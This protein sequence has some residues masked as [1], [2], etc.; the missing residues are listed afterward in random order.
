MSERDPKLTL[1]QMRDFASRAHAL[2]HG[3]SVDQVAANDML[4][5]ALERYVSLVGEA[6]TRLDR[7]F[8]ERY[9]RVPWHRIIG[10]RNILVHG[11]DA[12]DDQVLWDTASLRT[13]ELIAEID[14]ILP[15][16]PLSSASARW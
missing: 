9:P 2:T 3:R 1:E 12:I 8:H 14:R 4:R 15:A 6:A 10:M 5:G 11:Y 16:L 7:S 13:V